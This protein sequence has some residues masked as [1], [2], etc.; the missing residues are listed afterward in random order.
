MW[1][2]PIVKKKLIQNLCATRK[3]FNDTWYLVLGNSH[4]DE[5]YI[6]SVFGPKEQKE[7]EFSLYEA[8]NKVRL[9]LSYLLIKKKKNM[10]N[11]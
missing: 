7:I 6:R 10:K 2:H 8:T 4:D 11:A 3:E 9:R 5:T 1:W